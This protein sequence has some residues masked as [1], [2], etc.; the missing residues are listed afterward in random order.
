[1]NG[2]PRLVA[3]GP[4]VDQKEKAPDLGHI[5]SSSYVAVSPV[6][7]VAGASSS[8]GKKHAAMSLLEETSCI[9]TGQHLVFLVKRTC[10]PDIQQQLG[11]KNRD[12]KPQIWLEPSDAWIVLTLRHTIKRDCKWQ[13]Y[14][15][16]GCSRAALLPCLRLPCAHLSYLWSICFSMAGLAIW[17]ADAVDPASFLVSF[18]EVA[19]A[20]IFACSPPFWSMHGNGVA[21]FGRRQPTLS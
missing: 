3:I 9:P 18:L 8:S 16:T 4:S 5:Q 21:F 14:A 12:Y 15:A 17:L 6:P 10:T 13:D 19:S 7:P 1:M 11:S 2:R 20:R